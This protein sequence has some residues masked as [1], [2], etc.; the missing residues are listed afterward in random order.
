MRLRVELPR[1]IRD[2]LN[3]KAR[4]KVLYGGRDGVSATR[5][6][7]LLCLAS[8]PACLDILSPSLLGFS[9]L[10]VV[11]GW[12]GRTGRRTGRA[13]AILL[14]KA[15]KYITIVRRI[16]GPIDHPT[17]HPSLGLLRVPPAM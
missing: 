14:E 15:Q 9:F 1:K 13:F 5:A 3:A 4:Y 17:N 2:A 12:W 7:S 8:L 16:K 6:S 10:D 11:L